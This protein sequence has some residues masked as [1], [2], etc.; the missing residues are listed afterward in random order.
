MGKWPS[1]TWSVCVCVCA[2]CI[3]VE[4]SFSISAKS[5]TNNLY[6]KLVRFSIFGHLRLFFFSCCIF[7]SLFRPLPTRSSI[8]S[9]SPC[10]RLLTT[11]VVLAVVLVLFF[12]WWWYALCQLC[13][14]CVRVRRAAEVTDFRI[15]N[16]V[17]CPSPFYLFGSSFFF[18]FFACSALKL[19]YC[20]VGRLFNYSSFVYESTCVEIGGFTF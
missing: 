3:E 18:L 10:F 9:S 8:H 12:L 1:P 17:C 20:L 2:L 5:Y 6:S 19:D 14:A 7:Y 13:L 4:T 11:S 16:A 15:V